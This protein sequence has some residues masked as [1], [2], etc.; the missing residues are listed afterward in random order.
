VIFGVVSLTTDDLLPQSG[1]LLAIRLAGSDTET[2]PADA[3]RGH[4]GCRSGLA[5]TATQ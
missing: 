2:P 4:T 5:A 1:A 3:Q